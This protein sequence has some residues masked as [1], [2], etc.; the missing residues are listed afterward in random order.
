MAMVSAHADDFGNEQQLVSQLQHRSA[1]AQGQLQAVQ[2]GNEISMTMV[3]QMQKM[4]QLQMAQMN[5]QNAYL[6]EQKGRQDAGD[7]AQNQ[8]YGAL[9]SNNVK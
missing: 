9:R 2:A 3:G 4:R 1:S 5:A 7:Q 8:A 6:T